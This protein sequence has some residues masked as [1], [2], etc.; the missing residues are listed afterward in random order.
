MLNLRF[1]IKK[2]T[3][4]LNIMNIKQQ[5]IAKLSKYNPLQKL[6]DVFKANL[7]QL[8]MAVFRKEYLK[9]LEQK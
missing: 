7:K 9:A 3:T 5:P 8:S 6:F 1:L 2:V 4:S